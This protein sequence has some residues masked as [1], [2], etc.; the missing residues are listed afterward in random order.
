M[1]EMSILPNLSLEGDSKHWKNW[2]A[3]Y[4]DIKTCEDCRKN[5]GKIYN[6]NEKR[7]RPEHERCRCTIVPMRTKEVGS[8]TDRGFDGADAWLMYRNRLPDYYVTKEEAIAAG[9]DSRQGNLANVCPDKMIGG[10]LY[11]NRRALLPT[12][13][14]R[15]WREADFDFIDGYRNNKRILYSNDG[16]I[17]VSYDHAQTFYELIK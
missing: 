12:A 15:I 3:I 9:W 4:L 7:Y 6:F 14:G 17:F 5:H 13:Q 2:Q 8:A 11:K 1:N 10:N 16:L